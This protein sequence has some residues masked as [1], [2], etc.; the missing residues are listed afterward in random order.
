MKSKKMIIAITAVLTAAIALA[1]LLIIWFYGDSYRDFADF[2]AE[3]AIPGLDDGATPQGITSYR[4]INNSAAEKENSEYFFICAYMPKK[5]KQPQPSRIYV[6]EKTQG[7]IGYVNLKNEDGSWHTGHVGGIATNGTFLWIS[8]QLKGTDGETGTVFVAKSKE[9]YSTIAQEII[10]KA[11]DKELSDDDRFI[12]FT[13]SFNAGGN[14]SFLYYYDSDANSGNNTTAPG[15]GDMLYVGE[16]YRKGKFNTSESHHID[17]KDDNKSNN[18]KDD[19]EDDK[20]EV[21]ANVIATNR[22]F[23]YEYSV[24]SYNYS[25]STTGLSCIGS[26]AV[27]DNG[28]DVPRVQKIFSIPNEIQGFAR[29]AGGKLVLSQSYGLKNS[30]LIYYDWDKVYDANQLTENSALYKTLKG[31]AFSYEGVKTKSGAPANEDNLN[32][33]SKVRVYYVYGENEKDDSPFI[34]YYSVP[35]MSEGLCASGERINVLFESGAKKYRKFVRRILTDV[36]SFI[37]SKNK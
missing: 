25:S 26:A 6:T 5:N 14:A 2:K 18:N 36:Y 10:K 22:A 31:H 29:T 7:Y 33:S 23:V 13:A 4:Y 8:S 9:T 15:S 28:G 3:A 1:L 30:H 17:I 37:P 20:K 27:A 21:K 24:M 34:K 32:L 12:Q 19:K 16:F 11:S 35:S